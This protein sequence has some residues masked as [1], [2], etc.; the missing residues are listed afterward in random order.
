MFCRIPPFISIRSSLNLERLS[1]FSARGKQAFDHIGNKRFRDLV[2]LHQENYANAVCKYHKSKIVSHIV[3]TVHQQSPQGGFV[4]LIKGVWYEIGER[5]AK[6]KVGQTFRDF[7][8]TKY[9]S[10][11]KAKARARIQQ[12]I[13]QYEY[14]N[15]Q[16]LQLTG[17]DRQ[18]TSESD[19]RNT[20][21]DDSVER[22]VYPSFAPKRKLPSRID[23]MTKSEPENKQ[24]PGNLL[25]DSLLTIDSKLELPEQQT[26]MPQSD[27]EPLSLDDDSI[28]DIDYLA[29]P[30][31]SRQM[32]STFEADMKVFAEF[33]GIAA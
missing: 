12:R 16:F 19:E 28:G 21:D 3:N 2:R 27:I 4:R 7:L 6:E 20:S 26:S 29:E 15:T 5:A 18:D 30:D 32:S 11:T 22:A 8:H 1:P 10:S 25:F 14:E 24:E 17:F 13:E 33:M 31:F 9:T 23:V